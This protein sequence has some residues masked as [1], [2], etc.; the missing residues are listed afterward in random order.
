M[1]LSMC[2]T[3]CRSALVVVFFR[4]GINAEAQF[5]AV[6]ELLIRSH[7]ILQ[8]VGQRPVRGV[9]NGSRVSD[10]PESPALPTRRA[11][12]TTSITQLRTYAQGHEERDANHGEDERRRLD[13]DRLFI[14]WA[15]ANWRWNTE[16]GRTEELRGEKVVPRGVEA[17]RGTE[18]DVQNLD[19]AV[20]VRSARA[21]TARRRP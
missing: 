8:A 20:H 1:P 13:T 4:S 2:S 9:S 14:N 10:Q 12:P 11:S 16:N 15:S 5:G 21:R 18:G 19:H 17:P 7:E 6:R 3:K